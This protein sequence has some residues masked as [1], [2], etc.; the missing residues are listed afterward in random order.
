MS[1]PDSA[2]RAFKKILVATDLSARSDRAIERAVQIAKASDAELRV[3]HIVDDDLPDR[4][5]RKL[6]A[7]AEE[8]IGEVDLPENAEIAVITGKDYRAITQDAADWEA[9]LTVLGIHRVGSD[10]PVTGTTMERVVRMGGRPT[11][12]VSE[13][14][15][16]PYKRVVVA[17][18]FSMHARYALR[19]AAT[20]CPD[21]DLHLVHVFHVPFEGFQYGSETRREYRDE[22]ARDLNR[23]VAEE[24]EGLTKTLSDS[25]TL[26]VHQHLVHGDVVGGLSEQVQ[27]LKPDLLAIGTHGRTGI[28]RA[29]IGSVAAS[30]LNK[31]PCDVLAVKAW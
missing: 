12:V 15:R 19:C 6:V 7:A 30:F 14:A 29:L 3:I 4:I 2:G 16:E 21:A 9:D 13:R 25:A 27:E 23:L 11:L 22:Y 17:T 18:D 26:N 5:H 28:A 1:G 10:K 8:E 31:P 20:L 24:M